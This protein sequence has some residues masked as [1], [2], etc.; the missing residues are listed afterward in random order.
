MKPGCFPRKLIDRFSLSTDE[1]ALL[2]DPAFGVTVP[3]ML[4]AG[5]EEKL[6][7]T[8]ADHEIPRVL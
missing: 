1:T 2:I 6:R 3:I 8:R 5:F 7:D 4:R